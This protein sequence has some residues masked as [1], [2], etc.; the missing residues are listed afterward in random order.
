[1]E[2]FEQIKKQVLSLKEQKMSQRQIATTLN[3]SL[4]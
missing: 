2:N 1:M 4:Y 3:I